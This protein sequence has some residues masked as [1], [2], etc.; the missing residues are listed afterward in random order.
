MIEMSK[1]WQKQHEMLTIFLSSSSP[2]Q[3][4]PSSATPSMPSPTLAPEREFPSD[5]T[6]PCTY[7]DDELTSSAHPASDPCAQQS[8]KTARADPSSSL[9]EPTSKLP[10]KKKDIVRVY[11]SGAA[12]Y[13]AK[14]DDESDLGSHPDHSIN[15]PENSARST[16]RTETPSTAMALVHAFQKAQG[17]PETRRQIRQQARDT[18]VY[19]E[20]QA[21]LSQP[22]TPLSRR[23][24]ELKC[25]DRK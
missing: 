22:K 10:R 3:L 4:T 23:P 18:Q 12:F 8:P 9:T 7:P 6:I 25:S 19:P 2:T 11:V 21:L 16:P 17:S 5:A 15:P 1:T 14:A 24:T 20:F 13:R